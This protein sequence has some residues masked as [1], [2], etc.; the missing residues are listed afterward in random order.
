[1]RQTDQQK[2]I[3]TQSQALLEKAHH[4]LFFRVD[5]GLSQPRTAQ[6]WKGPQERGLSSPPHEM[7]WGAPSGRRRPWTVAVRLGAGWSSTET[8]PSPLQGPLPLLKPSGSFVRDGESA[9]LENF[10]NSQQPLAPPR[11]GGLQPFLRCGIPGLESPPTPGASWHPMSP[12]P[13]EGA[14]CGSGGSR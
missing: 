8:L 12:L 11:V 13:C 1:M 5:L 7:G 14:W 4:P 10:I 6:P 2:E 3:L 9:L